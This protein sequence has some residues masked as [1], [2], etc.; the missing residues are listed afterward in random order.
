MGDKVR[1]VRLLMAVSLAALLGLVAAWPG[2]SA[3]A[4]PPPSYLARDRG[5][6]SRAP[7]ATTFVAVG[8]AAQLSA[9]LVAEGE[10]IRGLEVVDGTGR[11]FVLNPNGTVSPT[12][13]VVEPTV[14]RSWLADAFSARW[15]ALQRTPV[16][17][18]AYCSNAKQAVLS[19]L[20]LPTHEGT[21]PLTLAET[22]D[23]AGTRISA[24]HQPGNEFPRE[25]RPDRDHRGGYLHNLWHRIT[26]TT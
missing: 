15:W 1:K 11:V 25:C 26:G 18:P 20:T 9:H 8:N 16:D 17:G 21:R 24:M 13:A 4:D 10:Y 19:R 2:Q 23:A 7:S 6:G 22:L 3:V 5:A 12:G 14:V